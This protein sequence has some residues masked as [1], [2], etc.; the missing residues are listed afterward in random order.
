MSSL[1]VNKN[2]EFF[3]A[4]CEK[5]DHSSVSLG[6]KDNDGTIQ[7]LASFGKIYYRG[8]TQTKKENNLDMFKLRLSEICGAVFTDTNAYIQ[9]E[10]V[11]AY[12]INDEVWR[13]PKT[14]DISYKAYAITYQHYLQFLNQM[15][16]ISRKQQ[17]KFNVKPLKAYFP[18][19]ENDDIVKL[20]WEN[21][22]HEEEIQPL[23]NEEFVTLSIGNNCRH[24]AIH[25][26]EEARK[27]EGTGAGISSLFFKSLPLKAVLVGGNVKDNYLFVLPL[28]P[29][30]YSHVNPEK[31]SILTEL[32][33]RL[34]EMV[35]IAQENELSRRKFEKL[36]GLYKEIATQMPETILDV[37]SSI[38]SWEKEN[39]ELI[40]THREKH[41]FHFATATERMFDKFRIKFASIKKEQEEIIDPLCNTNK[42]QEHLSIKG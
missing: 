32:Y 21:V 37:I 1:L 22:D 31:L 33:I 2:N 39:K 38:E 20:E 6:V 9:N 17:I 23:A 13:S 28:P 12:E 4:I 29:N 3:I 25:L 42:V 36:K 40:S 18:V 41:W 34:D 35:L 26:T 19:M 5:N 15:A 14:S 16:A 27:T 7:F 8:A 24:S 10:P 30:A 11:I